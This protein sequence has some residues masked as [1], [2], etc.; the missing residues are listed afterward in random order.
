MDFNKLVDRRIDENKIV[1]NEIV[2]DRIFEAP[3]SNVFQCF[4]CGFR[5]RSTFGV[6][7][8]EL[9]CKGCGGLLEEST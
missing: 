4:G 3:S 8:E 2:E 9:P 6:P 7:R 5:Q 1:K